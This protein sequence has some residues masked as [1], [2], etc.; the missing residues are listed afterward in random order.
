[1]QYTPEVAPPPLIMDGSIG[2]SNVWSISPIAP[3]TV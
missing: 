1:M 2:I 3:L